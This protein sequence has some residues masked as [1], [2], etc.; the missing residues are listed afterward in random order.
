MPT[1][2]Q[3]GTGSVKAGIQE[4]E[5]LEQNCNRFPASAGMTALFSNYDTVSKGEEDKRGEGLRPRG[6]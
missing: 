4:D 2:H 5:I 3:D 1:L 6:L